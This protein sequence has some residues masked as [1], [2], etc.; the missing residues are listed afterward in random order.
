MEDLLPLG[1]RIGDLQAL[2]PALAVGATVERA[3]GNIPVA[4]E[5]VEELEEATRDNAVFRS[6]V[7]AE[8]VRVCVAASNVPLAE[9]LLTPADTRGRHRHVNVL[10]AR[11]MVA[12][13]KDELEQAAVLH[14]HAA[15]LWSEYGDSLE[16]GHGLLGAGRCLV[17][18]GRERDAAGRLEEA[19]AIFERL[20]AHP[21][22]AEIDE[23]LGHRQVATGG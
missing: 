2:A 15:E 1:R 20:G 12:E 13:A 8:C 4:I 14:A 22:V 16:R 6:R 3:R 19:R 11:A 9:S 21:L 23:Q 5:L 18:L 10:S 17:R 7:V